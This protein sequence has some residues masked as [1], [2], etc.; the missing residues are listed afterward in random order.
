M[1]ASVEAKSLALLATGIDSVFD[2]GANGV[3]WWCHWKAARM[4]RDKWPVG[5][6]RLETIGNIAFGSLYDQL[7]PLN[8]ILHSH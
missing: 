2:I 5:G 4:D 3:L 1:W 8:T 7:S 6:E